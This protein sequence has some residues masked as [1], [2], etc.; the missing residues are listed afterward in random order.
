MLR[1]YK[2]EGQPASTGIPACHHCHPTWLGEPPHSRRS[3]TS[4]VSI[5]GRMLS[6]PCTS[7]T[8]TEGFTPHLGFT[9]LLR[10]S[11]MGHTKSPR[12]F[13]WT[14]NVLVC[15]VSAVKMCPTMY[16]VGWG[17]GLTSGVLKR[18]HLPQGILQPFVEQIEPSDH[19]PQR[20]SCI[21][22][23]WPTWNPF[24]GAVTM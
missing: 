16:L 12:M 22:Y 6:S 17:P 1:P 13:A 18:A 23:G 2:A 3:R 24:R 19:P 14:S 8:S 15:G 4:W 7:V 9:P 21:S 5:P 11:P 20:L 10:I